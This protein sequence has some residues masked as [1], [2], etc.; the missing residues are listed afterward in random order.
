ML[1]D[2]K[3]RL[4]NTRSLTTPLEGVQQQ[5]GMNTIL[6][7][8]ILDFWRNKY[9]WR[10]REKF[11]NKYPQFLTNIHGLDVHYLHVKPKPAEGVQVLPLLLLHGWSGSVREF[12]GIIPLLTEVQGG[13]NIVFEVIAPSLP[14][15][16]FSAASSKPGLSAT[17]M[18]VMLKNLMLRLGFAE[19]YVQGGDWG[20]YISANIARLYPA[21]VL[22]LHSTFCVV[23]TLKSRLKMFLGSLY[24]SAVVRKEFRHKMYP[25]SDFYANFWLETA[26]AHIQATKPE[27]IGTGSCAVRCSLMAVFYVK[28]RNCFDG[29]ASGFGG[30]FAGEV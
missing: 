28:I 13:K 14:G 18:A 6:L 12:Y 22:G 29:F 27:T 20:A 16:G 19:F 25:L 2:L 4:D 24:P 5:Y 3:S 8:E 15:H 1:L 21:H 26:Y 7:G 17:Q 11:L 23:D 30:V 9:E 10:E